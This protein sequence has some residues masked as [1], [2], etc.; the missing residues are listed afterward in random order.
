MPP[1]AMPEE[2]KMLGISCFIGDNGSMEPASKSGEM[3]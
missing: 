1:L 2:K 3:L